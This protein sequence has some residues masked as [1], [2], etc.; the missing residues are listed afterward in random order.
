MRTGGVAFPDGRGGLPERPESALT[1][2]SG[3]QAGS[4]HQ[5]FPKW[6]GGAGRHSACLLKDP[7]LRG[8]R[9]NTSPLPEEPACEPDLWCTGLDSP[10]KGHSQWAKIGEKEPFCVQGWGVRVCLGGGTTFRQPAPLP[11]L[12]PLAAGAVLR[13]K[14]AFPVSPPPNFPAFLASPENRLRAQGGGWAATR[15]SP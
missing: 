6:L 15:L 3:P 9:K 5:L 12:P 14:E 7:S 2:A 10:L 11:Q 4:H 13:G 1:G 8:S